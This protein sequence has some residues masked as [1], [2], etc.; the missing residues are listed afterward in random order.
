MTKLPERFPLPPIL[1]P[2][3]LPHT[4]PNTPSVWGSCVGFVC[5]LF[6]RLRHLDAETF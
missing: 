3:A 4:D 1:F 6:A 2:T 5:G